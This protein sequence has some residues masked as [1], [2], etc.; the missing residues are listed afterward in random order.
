MGEK[1]KQFQTPKLIPL[2]MSLCTKDGGKRGHP[3]INSKD[4]YLCLIDG[5]YFTGTF[6][7]VWY[8]WS[9]NGWHGVGL[10][11]DPPGTNASGW[12]QIWKLEAPKVGKVV[13]PEDKCEVNGC[14]GR[15]KRLN[16]CVG[17]PE[18]IRADRQCRKCGQF[19]G[20]SKSSLFKLSKREYEQGL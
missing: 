10:Q 12:Q 14:K 5:K 15:L 17:D 11:F 6:S 19:Y 16:T 18:G 8:G 13:H 1:R 3:D 4:T 2:D 20:C 9:F 7:S